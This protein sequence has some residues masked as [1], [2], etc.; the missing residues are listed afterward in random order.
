MI[1]PQ[2][3]DTNHKRESR[4]RGHRLI[5]CVCRLMVVSR[6]NRM[7]DGAQFS[8]SQA[9]LLVTWPWHAGV[10]VM[11]GKEWHQWAEAER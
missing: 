10:W 1:Q 5:C 2:W 7:G 3:F 9:H 6:C 4:Q 11:T 8:T